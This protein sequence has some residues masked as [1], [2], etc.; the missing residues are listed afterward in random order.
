[1]PC[2]LILNEVIT[3]S[4][5]H[6]FKDRSTCIIRVVAKELE[7][8]TLKIVISDNGCGLPAGFDPAD[9]D[10]LG[11]SLIEAL[12]QQLGARYTFETSEEG[13]TFSMEFTPQSQ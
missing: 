13:T 6:A 12:C 2:G 10:T 1:M 9:A 11:M 4:T 3:N 8:E 7:G 5:K